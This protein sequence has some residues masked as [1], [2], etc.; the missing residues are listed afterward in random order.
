MK[1]LKPFNEDLDKG[2][3]VSA[4]NKLSALKHTKRAKKLESWA[5]Q[6]KVNEKIRKYSKYGEIEVDMKLPLTSNSILKFHVMFFLDDFGMEVHNNKGSF[7]IPI[8]LIPKDEETLKACLSK[9]EEYQ[10]ESGFI[11]SFGISISF[12]VNNDM[13]NYT[14]LKFMLYDEHET[15]KIEIANR[16]SAVTL[17]KIIVDGIGKPGYFP[18]IRTHYE[19]LYEEIDMQIGSILR[20]SSEYGFTPESLADY[21]KSQSVNIFYKE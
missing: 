18:A 5:I 9:M 13:I 6:S 11:W 1:Y 3:Y 7:W 20:F 16:K 8:T 4:A 19:S 14:D 10:L 21:I 17:K 2:T 12:N 15:G